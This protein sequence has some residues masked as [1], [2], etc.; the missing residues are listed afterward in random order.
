MYLINRE[1]VT[2]KKNRPLTLIKERLFSYET[3]FSCY[4]GV[5]NR[6]FDSGLLIRIHDLDESK[7]PLKSLPL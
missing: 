4:P 6:L 3:T 7:A 5:V 1:L 2:P